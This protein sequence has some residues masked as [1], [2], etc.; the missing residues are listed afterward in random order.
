M[1]THRPPGL[2]KAF[3]PMP[4]FLIE[5]T[6]IRNEVTD[7]GAVGHDDARV[8]HSADVFIGV[9]S[10]GR[11]TAVGFDA[12]LETGRRIRRRVHAPDDRDELPRQE[13]LGD[14]RT[15]VPVQAGSIFDQRQLDSFG[16]A[17][18][19]PAPRFREW[20]CRSHHDWHVAM[21]PVAEE[22]LSLRVAAK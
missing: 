18:R 11:R 14:D 22:Q 9:K 16:G 1:R 12:D 17:Q 13:F 15:Q 3:Q 19:K 21:G 6:D 10:Q 4:A 2:I 8:R 7:A 5:L 20:K